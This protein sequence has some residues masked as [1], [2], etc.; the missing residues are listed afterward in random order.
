M[1]QEGK[2]HGRVKGCDNAVET[3]T[4]SASE[5]EREQRDP[6]LETNIPEHRK[7][8]KGKLNKKTGSTQKTIGSMPGGDPCLVTS[9]GIEQPTKR[10][11]ESRVGGGVIDPKHSEK[12]YSKRKRKSTR[13]GV[14]LV[15]LFRGGG[16]AG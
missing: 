12:K 13:H 7:Q 16:G 15:G 9:S 14:L 5:R 4:N 3:P 2:G 11:R 10:Y 6:A 1:N 8:N